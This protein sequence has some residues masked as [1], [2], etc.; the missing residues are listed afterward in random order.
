M[1]NLM[2]FTTFN[3]LIKILKGLSTFDPNNLKCTYYI[4]VRR[5]KGNSK[6]RIIGVI[7]R[8]PHIGLQKGEKIVY[9]KPKMC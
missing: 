7:Q 3:I 2:N 9:P 4:K 6:Y 1:F 8:G 5:E